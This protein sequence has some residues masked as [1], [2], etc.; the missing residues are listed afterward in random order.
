MLFF[1]FITLIFVI[2]PSWA[3]RVHPCS[4]CTSLDIQRTR[5]PKMPIMECGDSAMEIFC[6]AMSTLQLQATPR[7]RARY[8]GTIA[9]EQGYT[10]Q[11]Q[12]PSTICKSIPE[13]HP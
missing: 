3:L 8:R 9:R 2:L 1:P 11:T 6:P 10:Q 7:Y 4:I 13:M 5:L 12:V